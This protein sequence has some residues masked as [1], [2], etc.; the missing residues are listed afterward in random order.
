[1][2]NYDILLIGDGN[3]LQKTIG[4]VLEYKGFSVKTTENPEAALEALVRK[5]YDLVVARI[6]SNDLEGV[7]ILKRAKRLNPAVKLMVV[8]GNNDAIFPLEA[9]EVEVDDYILMPVSPA[10]LWRRVSHCLE[11]RQVIDI[12]PLADKAQISPG[13][14]KLGPEAMLML[15][16]LRGSIV[17]VAGSLKLVARGSYGEV[18]D[19]IK[20]KIQE[21]NNRL[22]KVVG[23]SED[24]IARM[25]GGPHSQ[26]ARE[27]V[28]D[29]S[30][31]V[32]DSIL[33]E[34]SAELKEQQV[35]VVNR[36]KLN[37]RR[38][39]KIPIKGNKLWLQC[40]FRNLVNNCINH[41]GRGCTIV[42][43]F[44]KD[45]SGGRLNVYNSGKIVPESL[46][47]MLFSYGR[48]TRQPKAGRQGLGVG[49]SLSR[50]LI[51]DQGGDLWYEPKSDGSQFVVAL[52]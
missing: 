12:Q 23:L 7:D 44:E 28:L 27:E 37:Q 24:F 1:M 25:L 49:L 11:D 3:N 36:L 42:V 33:A 47:A 31:D 19:T 22:E 29:L 38:N 41:G 2:A 5:N 13:G 52:P 16:D 10:E 43:D 50:D 40:V 17:S 45:G 30:A 48:R 9:Y 18:D 20:A 26:G 6:T 34:L 14:H 4:W 15:H 39:G 32:V 8:S 21:V 35:R 46:R 51:Q